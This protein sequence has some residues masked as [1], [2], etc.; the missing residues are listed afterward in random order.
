[1]NKID[2]DTAQPERVENELLELF[3]NLDATDE[4][5]EYP[6]LYTSAKQGYCSQDATA[7]KGTL[8]PLLDMVIAKV[9]PPNV[10][11]DKPFSMLVTQIEQDPYIGK[12]YLGSCPIAF[13]IRK[14]SKWNS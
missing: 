6:I 8:L 2:R 3:I 12:C 9:P 5:L 13:I 10:Q 11:T 4:Q 1:M 14:N 7:R